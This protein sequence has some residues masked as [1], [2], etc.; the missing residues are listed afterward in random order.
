M[1]DDQP[2]SVARLTMRA[3]GHTVT[4]GRVYFVSGRNEISCFPEAAS[5]LATSEDAD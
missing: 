4:V 3:V 5:G 1:T 2:P